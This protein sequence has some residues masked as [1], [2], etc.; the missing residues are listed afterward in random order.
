MKINKYGDNNIP[1]V[2]IGELSEKQ[3]CLYGVNINLA[4]AVPFVIDGLKPVQRRILY[5]VYK[6]YGKGKFGVASA[7]GDLLHIY[8]HGDLGCADTFARMSQPFSNAV[9]L[10]DALGNGGNETSEGDQAAPRYLSMKLSKFSLDVLFDEFDGKVNMMPN[11]DGTT[12]EPTSLPAKFPL[13]LLNGSS[14]IG[15]SLSSTIPPF[16]LNEVADATIKLLKNPSAKIHLV[17]DSPTSC[18]IIIK[19]DT[20]FIMQSSY[21]VDNINYTITIK[22]TPYGKYLDNIN[23]AICDMQLSANNIPQLLSAED[24]SDLL[25][26]GHLKYVLRCKPCNL[27]KLVNDIFTRIP[28]FRSV[29]STKNMNVVDSGLQSRK[30]DCRQILLSWITIRLQEKR[31]WYLRQLTEKNIERNMMEGKAFMLSKENLNKT[32]KTFSSCKSKADII[33]ALVEAYKKK[34]G[35]LQVSSSQ[36]NYIADIPMHS[37]TQNECEKTIEKLNKLNEEINSIHD[38]VF[39]PEKVKEVIISEIKTIKEKYGVPRRSKIINTKTQDNCN[40]GFVQILTNGS[41]KF[42]ETDNPD[43]LSSDITPISGDKVCLIDTIGNSVWVNVNS[44]EQDKPITL[45]SIGNIVMTNCVAAVSNLSNNIVALTNKGRIKY[46][47]INKLPSNASKKTIMPLQEDEQ[48]VSIIEVADEAHDILVYTNDGQGKRIAISSLNKVSSL[49]SIGQFIMGTCDNVSGMFIIDSSKPYLV[50][51]TKLGR[52]RV[53][54]SK[55]LMTGKKFAGTKSI[56]SLSQQDD[57]IAVFCVSQNSSVTLYHADSRIS[58]VNISSLPVSTM[59]EE[60]K[61][62]KH[63]P[64]VKVIRAVI[65]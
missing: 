13:I 33:P 58:E 41:V 53:N 59:S 24:E 31:A 65:S 39:D 6:T 43:N 9:P 21:E 23:K 64:G 14:G 11:Y 5:T 28:G 57:L 42:S 8:P 44:I 55:F 36:A 26:D 18:D 3:M 62:P 2:E 34:D 4:R 40:I 27:Y 29:I 47:P 45:T 37:L 20:T 35:T 61:R 16:N 38:I 46:I 32:I 51:V 30:Y 7:V 54:H 50:Y 49:D 63:V 48:I 17:P 10:L 56:I 12:N 52:I 25:T 1:N 60:P 15:Y 19:D 22:N